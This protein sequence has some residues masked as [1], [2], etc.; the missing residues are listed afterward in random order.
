MQV[1]EL[2]KLSVMKFTK[3]RSVKREIGKEF[4]MAKTIG[5]LG[6]GN[7]ASGIIG[8]LIDRKSY[9]PKN[10]FVR[11]I[12]KDRAAWLQ[13]QFGLSIVESNEE[14]AGKTNL[15]VFAV[16]PQDGEKAGKELAPYIKGQKT[17]VSI[18]AG[19]QIEKLHA[20]L[21]ENVSIARIMPNTM[22][23]S[24]RGYSALTFDTS[25]DAAKKEEVRGITESIGK[26]LEIPESQFDAFTASSCAG[27]EWLIL[28]AGALVDA[29]VKTGL[30][31]DDVRKIVIENLIATGKVLENTDRH[32]YQITDEMNT[33]GGIGI[34]GLHTWQKAGLHGIIMDAV[35]AA[36]KRTTGLGK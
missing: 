12:N 11:E 8:G 24:Q 27:P 32:F 23:E 3:L 31:R 25:F 36:Y 26:T 19:S 20:W 4:Q 13:K 22:I 5:F 15:I 28:Y 21:G 1:T 34:A 2:K 10:I 16:K 9:E 18:L 14:L 35:E 29:G 17:I 6:G 30:N 33:P 7:M